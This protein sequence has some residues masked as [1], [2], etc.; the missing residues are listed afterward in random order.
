LHNPAITSVRRRLWRGRPLYGVRIIFSL[1]YATLTCYLNRALTSER[2]GRRQGDEGIRYSMVS[3]IARVTS[4][5]MFAAFFLQLRRQPQGA[6]LAGAV[7]SALE[8]L[9]AVHLRRRPGTIAS[10]LVCLVEISA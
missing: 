9:L 10:F 1:T 3:A 4:Y 5:P 6:L 8:R 2:G 7:V